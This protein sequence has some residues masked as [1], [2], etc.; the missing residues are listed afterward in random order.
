ML[1]ECCLTLLDV[2]T[3][4][5][6]DRK[7]R[8]SIHTESVQFLKEQRIRCLLQGSWFPVISASLNDSQPSIDMQKP[9][10][11]SWRFVRLSHDRNYLHYA[12][13]P[14]RLGREPSTHELP[15][16]IDLNT[17]S[18]VDSNVSRSPFPID[19]ELQA[20][21]KPVNGLSEKQT[22]PTQANTVTSLTLYGTS[23][24]LGTPGQEKVLLELSSGSS[25]R[26]SEWLDGL[27]MLLDQQPITADTN[28]L[29]D[30]LEG[31]SLKYR[32]INLRWEDVDWDRAQT[33]EEKE[34]P[35]RPTDRD[36][37]YDMD[38]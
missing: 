14:Q 19:T 22:P 34:L 6:L 24:S 26:A 2:L 11:S 1:S 32:M 33:R 21:Q 28:K 36:Y 23:S 25:S 9:V 7:L 31:W 38:D 16:R 30:V 18:S 10:V 35:P 37:W 15:H 13:H 12:S 4:L 8:Q 5:Q 27:L 29:I 17:V 20:S 3:Y